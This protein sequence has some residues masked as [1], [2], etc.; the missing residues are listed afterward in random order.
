M[1]GDSPLVSIVDDDIS[2]RE[3]LPPLLRLIGYAALTFPSAEA[4]LAS[5]RIADTRCLLLD[6]AMPGMSGTE[7]QEVLVQRHQVIPI[8]FVTAQQDPDLRP[9][10]LAAGAVECLYKPYSEAA[11]L[12]ALDTA[13]GINQGRLG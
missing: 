8:I 6:I 7:L 12:G 2:V 13:L 4:F 10:L 11:L 3:S 9:R 1:T 5:D